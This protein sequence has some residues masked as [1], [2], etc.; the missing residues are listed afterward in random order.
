MCGNPPVV[1]LQK[2]ASLIL[3][4]GTLAGEVDR[5]RLALSEQLRTG[6]TRA[7]GDE[8]KRSCAGAGGLR[9]WWAQPSRW[10]LDIVNRPLAWNVEEP[11]YSIRT[12][13]LGRSSG[14]ASL[15]KC[16]RIIESNPDYKLCY[17]R[18]GY[19]PNEDNFSPGIFD[20][21]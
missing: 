8:S 12:S 15:V 16:N 6:A 7:G 14:G 20:A 10:M 5:S 19:R 18:A 13:S 2:Q 3:T 4:G 9:L 1:C 21:N 17:G 11:R